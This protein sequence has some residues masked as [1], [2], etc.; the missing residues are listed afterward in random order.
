PVDTLAARLR[1][2]L[3]YALTG[4]QQRVLGEIAADLARPHPMH[5]LVQGDVGSGKTIVALLAALT[6]IEHGHQVAFMAPTELLAEQHFATIAALAEPLGVRVALLSGS[7]PRAAKTALHAA[8]AT[9]EIDLV[10]G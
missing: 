5:R 8:L 10:V 7:A 6:A 2:A 9:G 4:A 3:P 1:A